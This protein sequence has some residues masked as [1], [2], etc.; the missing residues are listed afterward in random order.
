MADVLPLPVPRAGGHESA[1]VASGTAAV[2]P[3]LGA[4]ATPAEEGLVGL[5]PG[6]GPVLA[7][8]VLLPPGIGHVQKRVVAE[9]VVAGPRARPPRMPV[10]NA[11]GGARKAAAVGAGNGQAMG[12]GG[13][14]KAA[15]GASKVGL[16]LFG[17][18]AHRPNALPAA[19]KGPGGARKHIPAAGQVPPL[20]EAQHVQAIARVA[21]TG[22]VWVRASVPLLAAGANNPGAQTAALRRVVRGHTCSTPARP[23]VCVHLALVGPSGLTKNR[24][25]VPVLVRLLLIGLRLRHQGP[26]LQRV[27]TLQPR[28]L[29]QL[30]LGPLRVL[31]LRLVLPVHGGPARPPQLKVPARRLRRPAAAPNK[32]LKPKSVPSIKCNP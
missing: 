14:G 26:R 11:V 22:V 31:V 1:I 15:R 5:P 24:G 6:V 23:T 32:A 30:M 17:A 25:G 18:H 13:A 20:K 8:A 10:P 4:A 16:P 29:H 21:A 19:Y 3:G 2:G 28:P 12:L 7:V 27:L 9:V